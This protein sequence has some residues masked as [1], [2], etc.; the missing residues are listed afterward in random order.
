MKQNE[1]HTRVF[2][3]TPELVSSRLRQT[4]SN[5]QEEEPV[6][7][8]MKLQPVLVILLILALCGAAVAAATW[9]SRDMMAYEE[10]DGVKRVNEELVSLITPIGQT[11]E[12]DALKVEVIDAVFD[13]HSLIAA[14][15]T[16]NKT[17][18]TL[19]LLCD[20]RTNGEYTG[21]GITSNTGER[22]L[23]P[24]DVLQSGISCRTDDI[25]LG[26]PENDATFDDSCEV[27]MRVSVLR[28][29]GDVVE[30][31]T[32]HGDETRGELDAYLAGIDAL[33]TEGKIPMVQDMIEY[34]S[35]IPYEEGMSTADMLAA[36]GMME[37]VSTL[38]VAFTVERNTK[39][40]SGLPGGDPVEKDNGSYILRVTRAEL[41]PNTG[42]FNL[43]RV[44]A[45]EEAALTYQAYHETDH[46][47]LNWDFQFLD[48]NGETS[49]SW[50]WSGSA[51]TQS[52]VEQ[53]DGTWVWAYRGVMTG[54]VRMPGTVAI[55]PTRDDP[56][57]GER[58]VAHPEEGITLEIR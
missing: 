20:I 24:G 28:P 49:W 54:L 37:L 14:W 38:D 39:P 35:S 12:D 6:K 17:S 2:G 3:P 7:K 47:N 48:E 13:G 9:G 58:S 16:T 52:P 26:T 56:E 31:E 33:I 1:T 21:A 27:K 25:V 42:T 41:T 19:Y 10:Q 46:T 34:G 53:P 40:K 18:D 15:T 11:F 50:N 29:R 55:V 43:E 8:K 30:I 5:I 4:L 44:F 22:F 51:D 45:N 57:T 32:L 23:Q 36:S